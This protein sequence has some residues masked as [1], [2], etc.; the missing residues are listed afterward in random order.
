MKPSQEDVY[1]RQED[2]RYGSFSNRPDAAILSYPVL[3]SGDEAH[4]GAFQALL[5]MDAA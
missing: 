1:K 2:G 4:R 3:T 5:G